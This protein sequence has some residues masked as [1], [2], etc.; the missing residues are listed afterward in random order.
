M[1]FARTHR[2][3]IAWTLFVF[4]LFNGLACS[5]GH[6]QMLGAFS[7]ALPAA[8]CAMAH[9]EAMAS[10]ADMPG[11]PGMLMAKAIKAPHAMNDMDNACAFAATVALALVFFVALGWLSRTRRVHPLQR[12]SVHRRPPRRAHPGIHPQAP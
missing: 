11:M 12:V 2:S 4:V 1:T 10:M 7:R 6:G 5:S 3:L 8:D 9:G